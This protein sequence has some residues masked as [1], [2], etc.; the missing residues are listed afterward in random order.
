MLEIQEINR[1]ERK[2]KMIEHLKYMGN[3][4]LASDVLEKQDGEAEICQAALS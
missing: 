2:S 3:V 1:E 4:R